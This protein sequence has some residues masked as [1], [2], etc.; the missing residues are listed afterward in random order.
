MKWIIDFCAQA[1]R[2]I[3]IGQGTKRDGFMMESGFAIAVSSE[4]MAILAVAKDLKDMRERMGRIV[5]AYDKQ[6]NPV[7]TEDLGVAGAMTA[8]MVDALKPNLL[9]TL[10]GQ[11]V[12]VHAGPFANIAI[13]QSS[14]IADRVALKLGDYVIT[15]SGF[16]ADIDF[17][18]FWKLK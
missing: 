10:E 1:L 4:V 15:E 13:G 18:K 16:D 3:T 6:G 9:Q 11:P 17:D 2:N 12:F 7:T 5:V 14:I 8:W